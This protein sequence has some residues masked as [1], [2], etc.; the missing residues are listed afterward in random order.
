VWGPVET[1][2]FGA[3]PDYRRW[4]WEVTR[5]TVG[6]LLTRGGRWW[7]EQTARRLGEPAELLY[8]EL[9]AR[10]GASVLVDESKAPLYGWFLESQPWADVVPVIF[11]RDPRAT[12]TSWSRPKPYRGLRGGHFP[13]QG[14]ASSAVAWMKRVALADRLFRGR[15]LVV[16]YEDFTRDPEPHLQRILGHAEAAPA[17]AG[18]HGVTVFGENHII[19]GNPD[20]FDRG[21]TTIRPAEPHGLG[22]WASTVVTAIA[23]PMLHRY[24]Y[25]WRA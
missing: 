8:R 19:V 22:T 2:L 10:T 12:A 11:V 17:P 4:E 20:K 7:Q 3:A 13:V 6:Q 9:T 15:G 1:A 24:G 18:H 14:S 23:S 21:P 25:G 5:P 16:R